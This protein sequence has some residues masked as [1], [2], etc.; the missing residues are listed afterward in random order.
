MKIKDIDHI[1]LSVKDIEKSMRFYHEVLDLPVVIETESRIEF[2]LGHQ[3]LVCVTAN[4]DNVKPAHPTPGSTSFSVVVRDPLSSIQSHLA[5]YFVPIIAGPLESQGH[6]GK[7]NSLFIND[8][9]KNLI[10]IR[11][12]QR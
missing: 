10:E 1:T 12:Y 9:D 11:E 7:M 3:R 8:P 6:N 4:D 2:Q 5:N